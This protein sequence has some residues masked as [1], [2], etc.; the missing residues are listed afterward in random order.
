MTTLIGSPFGPRSLAL[1][2]CRAGKIENERLYE[3]SAF[4]ANLIREFDKDY[5]ATVERRSNPTPIYNC[6]GLTFGSRRTGIF[7][8]KTI[9][10]ILSEDGYVQVPQAEVMEGDIIIY[11]DQES[12]DFEHSGIVVLRPKVE[13]LHVPLVCSKWGKY[14]EV[15]HLGNNCPYNFG[16]VR[17]YRGRYD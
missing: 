2:S 17:Y 3:I 4:E 8:S 11:F 9:S 7:E 16:T 14:A 13:N 10:Q 6:H 1:E 12:G 5:G 15:I